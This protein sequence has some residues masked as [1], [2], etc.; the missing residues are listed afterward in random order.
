MLEGAFLTAGSRILSEPA[1]AL[2]KRTPYPQGKTI[3]LHGRWVDPTFVAAVAAVESPLVYR[4][5]FEHHSA[6]HEAWGILGLCF[7]ELAATG[8]FQPEA[9]FFDMSHLSL[10]QRAPHF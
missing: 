10:A 4:V 8:P 2:Q 3:E 7:E 5:E 6:G 9:L 1:S